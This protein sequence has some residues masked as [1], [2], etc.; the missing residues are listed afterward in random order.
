MEGKCFYKNVCEHFFC[1]GLDAEVKNLTFISDVE[2]VDAWLLCL[3]CAVVVDGDFCTGL[4]ATLGLVLVSWPASSLGADPGAGTTLAGLLLLSFLLLPSRRAVS[5]LDDSLES[6]N[7]NSS[8]LSSE[9]SSALSASWVLLRS[10]IWIRK[11][12]QILVHISFKL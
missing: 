10:W 11:N 12:C 3:E 4:L 8:I 9:S 7:F 5:L 2:V 1:W 6:D